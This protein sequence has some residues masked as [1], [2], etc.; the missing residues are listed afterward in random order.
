M[1]DLEQHNIEIHANAA[2]WRRKPLLRDIYDGFYTQIASHLPPAELGPVVELGSGMGNI[3]RV[4]P[5]CI[6]TDL[7]SNSWLDRRENAYALSFA[8]KSIG[9]VVLFD[10]FHHLRYPGTVLREL[11]RVLQVGGRMIVFDPDMSMLGKLI[12][13]AFHHE[14]LGMRDTIAWE[15][16]ADFTA[17]SH[18]YYAAQGN[19]HRIFVQGERP[20]SLD[21]WNIRRVERQ[22]AL[23]YVVSGGFSGPQLY[24]HALLPLLRFMDRIARPLPGLFST[25]LLAVLE[26]HGT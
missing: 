25:R 23:G 15:T 9:A 4:I 5:G 2:A 1:T 3:K 26:K 14:P 11:H 18:G 22:P 16:P 10:V 12:Y 8:D 24:P 20:G 13:G 19:A 6:T 7:F 21:S 17:A